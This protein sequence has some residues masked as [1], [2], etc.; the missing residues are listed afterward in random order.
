MGMCPFSK[1]KCGDNDTIH[2]MS[3]NTGESKSMSLNIMPGETCTYKMMATCGLPNFKPENDTTGFD[4]QML[5][6]DDD[7]LPDAA[8]L[9]DL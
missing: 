5:E 6:Y 7:D 3:T 4:I 1:A 9:R 8:R 2:F